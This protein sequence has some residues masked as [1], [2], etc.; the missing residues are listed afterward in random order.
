MLVKTRCGMRDVKEKTSG[1]WEFPSP[2]QW[3]A[4]SDF[5]YSWFLISKN[6]LVYL[7]HTV[8]N[9]GDTV[10]SHTLMYSEITSKGNPLK[11][12]GQEC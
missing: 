9:H 1:M 7:L 2:K 3:E 10:I 12:I 4:P 5:I 8:R 6:K 11:Y